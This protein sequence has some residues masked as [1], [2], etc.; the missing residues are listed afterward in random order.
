MYVFEGSQVLPFIERNGGK[1]ISYWSP[2]IET[3]DWAKDNEIGRQYAEDL[4]AGCSEEDIPRVLVRT[5]EAI[6]QRGRFEGIEIGFFNR[7]GEIC[8][9]L[10]NAAIAKQ[11]VV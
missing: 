3:G 7:I 6:S 8:S 2:Q 11:R 4:I 1:I 9:S 10:R 5:T